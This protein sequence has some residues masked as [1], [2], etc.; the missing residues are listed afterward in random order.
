MALISP[1]LRLVALEQAQTNFL[2]TFRKNLL[3]YESVEILFQ[4]LLTT[5]S[6]FAALFLANY[7]HTYSYLVFNTSYVAYDHKGNNC[8]I[9]FDVNN[10][11]LNIL[12]IISTF[13]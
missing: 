7:K 12:I 13:Q 1:T 8:T 6:S 11:T 2:L 9:K 5:P 4:L 10:K 3:G